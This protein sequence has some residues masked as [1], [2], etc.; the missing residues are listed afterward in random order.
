MTRSR[1]FQA[2]SWTTSIFAFLALFV[3]EQ[4]FSELTQRM[5]FPAWVSVMILKIGAFVLLLVLVV[6]GFVLWMAQRRQAT[7]RG[8]N[9]K[10]IV[11]YADI[12]KM[13]GCK[14]VIHFD[15]CFTAHLG[16]AP[17]DIKVSSVCGQYLERH[18]KLDMPS[19]IAKAGEEP[20][21]VSRY[22]KTPAFVPGTIIPNG[23]DL[24]LAFA[25]LD[26]NGLARMDKDAYIQSLFVLWKQLELYASDKD[27]CMTVLG[28]NITRFNG[29][30]LSQQ[31]LLDV[32]LLTYRLSD[33][34]L[35][36]PHKLIICCQKAEGFS[37]SKVRPIV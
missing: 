15:E 1:F 5:D 22:Q 28:S 12:F 27:V 14:K 35:H 10:V 26:R 34:K 31:E 8:K 3:P 36:N 30:S 13:D 32:I 4:V 19:L 20:K 18:P 33:H 24:L 7:I 25:T 23:D 21:R 9:W 16:D 11:R 29:E 37:L 2:F 6:I 17:A